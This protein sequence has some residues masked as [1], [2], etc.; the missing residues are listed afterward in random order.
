MAFKICVVCCGGIAFQMHGYAYKKYAALH[1]DVVLAGCC[2]VDEKKSLLFKEKFGFV[3]AYGDYREMLKAEKPDAVCLNAPVSL[4]ASMAIDILNRG[5]PLMLEKPPGRTK[6]E[7]LSIMKAAKEKGVLHQVAFNRRFIPVLDVMVR[8]LRERCG[9]GGILNINCEFFRVNRKDPD[10]ST[11]AIHGIDTVRYAAGCDY[12]EIDFMYQEIPGYPEGVGNFF[13]QGKFVSGAA[14]QL[15]FCPF[16][17]VNL[18]R[19]TVVARGGGEGNS[20]YKAMLPY[21]GSLDSPGRLLVY[22]G[23]ALAEEVKGETLA[24]STEIF[25]TNGFYQEDS[26]FFDALRRGE[27]PAADLASAVQ[28]VEIAEYIRRRKSR[29]RL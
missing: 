26:S 6:E 2:D 8:E 27:Q 28:S 21:G 18:E 3:K 7:T 14:A 24:G 1:N 20:V 17:G 11:T 15:S 10:F 16:A 4:T 13:L 29:Y 22:R 25:E 19:I 12:R 23:D 5:Y 9:T